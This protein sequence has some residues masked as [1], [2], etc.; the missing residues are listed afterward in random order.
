MRHLPIVLLI[1]LS[2]LL[3]SCLGTLPKSP[4]LEPLVIELPPPPEDYSSI[5]SKMK[6]DLGAAPQPIIIKNNNITYFAFTKE[7]MIQLILFNETFKQMEAMLLSQNKQSNIYFMEI[8]TLKEL[9][10]SQNAQS[11]QYRDLYEATRDTVKR[12]KLE[13]LGYKVLTFGSIV[14]I[15]AVAVL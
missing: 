7:Q 10:E 5:L 11:K 15:I 4:K 14:A 9:A 1:V 2:L 12:A 6:T 8:K 13:T 3:T